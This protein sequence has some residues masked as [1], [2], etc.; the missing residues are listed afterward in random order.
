[1]A[2]NKGSQ[3][4]VTPQITKFGYHDENQFGESIISCPAMFA[5][6]FPVREGEKSRKQERT[7]TNIYSVNIQIAK[8]SW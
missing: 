4:S 1:M 7:P 6:G 5:M 2:R 8:R 3:T